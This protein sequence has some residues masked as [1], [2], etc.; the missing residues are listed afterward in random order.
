MRFAARFVIPNVS[1]EKLGI[2]LSKTYA[3]EIMTDNNQRHKNFIHI[4]CKNIDYPFLVEVIEQE[5]FQ[6]RLVIRGWLNYLSESPYLFKGYI[7]LR[8]YE[9]LPTH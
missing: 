7:E 3:A 2:D 4:Y 5:F 6:D 9:T 1:S 8:S